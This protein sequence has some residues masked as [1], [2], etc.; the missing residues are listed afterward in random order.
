MVN[1]CQKQDHDKGINVI[2]CTVRVNCVFPDCGHELSKLC[3]EEISSFQC[4]ELVLLKFPTCGHQM[5][6]LCYQK[7][8]HQEGVNRMKCTAI[9]D[10]ALP[11]CGH[12]DRKLC[13][14]DISSLECRKMVVLEFSDCGHQ[15]KLLCCEKQQHEEG[16]IKRKCTAQVVCVLPSCGHKDRKLCHQDVSSLKCK[17]MVLLRCSGCGNKEK[18]N[19]HWKQGYDE[20]T[21]NRTC[22]VKVDCV[23][24][25]CGHESTKLCHED[26]SS[27][28]CH[29]S[30]IL[31]CSSCGHKDIVK[32]YLKQENEKGNWKKKCNAKVDFVLPDCGHGSIKRCYE[33]IS[34][35]KCQKLVVLQ[36]AGCEQKEMVKC[37]L[38]QEHAKGNYKKK[39]FVKVECDLPVCG[40]RATKL[41]HEDE[42]NLKCQKPVLLKI[43]ACGHSSVVKCWKKQEHDTGINIQ[44]CS[45]RVDSLLPACKHTVAK[46][47]H[48]RLADV[49]CKSVVYFT[50]SCGHELSREC[51]VPV[52]QVQCEF[53]PCS[54]L[55]KC[56][57]P[58]VNKCYEPCDQGDCKAC[59]I[60]QIHNLK[61]N[62]QKA[63]D[64]VKKLRQQ[65]RETGGDFSITE[66]KQDGDPEYMSVHDRVTKYVLPMHNWYPH[67]TKIEKVH[68]LELE[69]QYE[70]YRASAFGDLEDLKFHGTDDAG[71]EGITRNGFR[72]GSVGMYGAGIYFATDSSK[73]SQTIYTKGSNKLLLCKVFLGRALTV[74][75]ADKFLTGESLRK[76]GY[77]S[78]FA[79]R[80]TK[81]TGG[82]LNDEFVV[83]DKRQAFVQYVIHYSTSTAG[84]PSTKVGQ[85]A[86]PGKPFQKVK[87]TPGRTINLNDPMELAYGFVEGHFHRMIRRFGV[88]SHST[89]RAIEFVVNSQLAANFERTKKTFEASKKGRQ[90]V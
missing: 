83:F 37:F 53:S 18:V 23:L 75:K 48:I 52:S 28:E 15:L 89:I 46:E 10:C 71:V 31:P 40:H 63:M 26:A 41:C 80:G 51:H 43:S 81:G 73:S 6:L 20:G 45:A 19:C 22:T 21:Y 32:C 11:S 1:C 9:V 39:C 2:R 42:A 49:I 47:C 4:Q 5:E 74:T 54:K 33:D 69:A 3:C 70:E 84:L 64:R 77:D 67:I 50:G 14:Q 12:E 27:I 24:P 30:V 79:P 87:L 35:F 44:K 65:I 16:I 29:K 86:A 25:L 8:Q 17:K 66:L 38:K 57:H 60:Q 72:V 88:N 59:R 78:V 58:C 62:Q 85:L 76:K 55:R 61:E 90:I 36:C 13:H 82:V 56:G 68:N 34:L 7:K